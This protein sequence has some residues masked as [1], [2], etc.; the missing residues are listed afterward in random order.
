MKHTIVLTFVASL[1]CFAGCEAQKKSAP[2]TKS[3]STTKPSAK[4]ASGADTKKLTK[5]DTPAAGELSERSDKDDTGKPGADD[6]PDKT[7]ADESQ[8]PSSEKPSSREPNPPPLP[9]DPP[10]RE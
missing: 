8:K 4:T 7:V 2:A 1:V 5:E 9:E 6:G 10:A 3:G